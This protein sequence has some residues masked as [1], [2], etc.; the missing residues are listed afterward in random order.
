MKCPKCSG[1]LRVTHTFGAGPAAQTRDYQCLDCSARFSSVTFLVGF[2]WE[3]PR[4]RK[5]GA[6]KLAGKIQREEVRL[7]GSD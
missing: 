2:D 6:R 3:G 5:S 4:R 7:E 1:D